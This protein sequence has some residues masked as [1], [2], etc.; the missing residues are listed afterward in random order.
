MDGQ[1]FAVPWAL[2]SSVRDDARARHR[3]RRPRPSGPGRRARSVRGRAGQRAAAGPSGLDLPIAAGFE[4]RPVRRCRGKGGAHA[5]AAGPASPHPQPCPID[6]AGLGVEDAAA[7]RAGRAGIEAGRHGIRRHRL[8]RAGPWRG[9]SGGR[10][11]PI[12]ARA[13][14]DWRDGC[15]H[16]DRRRHRRPRAGIRGWRNRRRRA[17]PPPA[18]PRG[19]RLPRRRGRQAQ[20]R[21]RGHR[22]RA[23][24]RAGCTPSR[25]GSCA[26]DGGQRA[27]RHPRAAAVPPAPTRIGARSNRRARRIR[28]PAAHHRARASSNARSALQGAAAS[29]SRQWRSSPT[30]GEATTRATSGSRVSSTVFAS[31]SI[32]R[33]SK[34]SPGSSPASQ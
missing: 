13:D 20:A 10:P 12:R 31:A 2:N 32:S 23:P 26:R 7:R 11:R 14:R 17:G 6:H 29:P 21:H 25:S 24:P 28:P 3:P 9:D 22:R 1:P 19:L 33:H 18:C 15:G 5:M 16:R 27:R 4:Q 8:Q 34:P 30:C